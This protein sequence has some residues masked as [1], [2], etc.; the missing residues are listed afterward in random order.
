MTHRRRRTHQL[1][2]TRLQL[3]ANPDGHPHRRPNLD[4]TRDLHPQPH[5]N[6]RPH[7]ITGPNPPRPT[8]PTDRYRPSSQFFRSK[9][10]D[11]PF[12]SNRVYE[13]LWG[14]EAEVRSF[15]DRWDGGIQHYVG[16]M[17]D[18]IEQL[19]RVLKPTGSLYLHCDPHASHYL[20][21]ML[22]Q[23]FGMKQFQNEVAWKRFSAKN[24][25]NRYGRSHD[26][27]FLYTKGKKF[28]WNVQYG[29]FEVDY[30]EQN[31]RYTEEET[32]RRYRLSD[33]TANKPGGDV[34]YE[35]HG[36]HP[37]KGRHWAYSRE[38]M[39]R[40]LAEGRIVFRR[41]GMPVYKRYLDE[42][43]GVP[44]QDIWTDIKL[45][46]GSK[47]RVGY[48]TQKPEALLERIITASSNSGDVVLDPFCGCGTTLIVAERLQRQWAG[49][50][51]SPTAIE[52]MKRRMWNY[53]RLTP[54]VIGAP[55]SIEDLKR[56]KPFEFQ[57]WIINRIHGT[58]SPRRTGDM[59]ID[60]YT[61]LDKSPVQVK[62][63]ESVGRN[64]VDNFETAIRRD[65]HDEG[66]IVAF[67][68]TKGAVEEAARAKWEERLN[69]RLVRVN[70]LL[71]PDDERPEPLR[72]PEGDV[73]PLPPTRKPQDMPSAEELI[74]SD[75]AT[76]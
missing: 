57:N 38:N 30:I 33:L 50:D 27:I 51:I 66:H 28:T 13:V 3:P 23:V 69:I 58:H 41:T 11:P 20:K 12:W 4:R 5:Q 76:G 42:Q 53:Y 74:H 7:R 54:N 25:P 18:R 24:D 15:E 16:W 31:Y 65:G 75:E 70:A 39:D 63:S 40:F 48:P 72:R 62:Q 17:R 71:K 9:Y 46:A 10:L 64:V 44:L 1:H 34:D 73:L 29:P 60:G 2:Q 67:S 8:P 36:M 47:E 37:Y 49:I 21:V 55:E 14:D 56:L 43:P 35:W 52:V 32:G 26:V 59:G 45:T 22:D 61:F 19:H 68:F 6:R